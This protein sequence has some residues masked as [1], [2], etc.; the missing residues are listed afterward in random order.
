[1]D[2]AMF[3]SK[4]WESDSGGGRDSRDSSDDKLG[5]LPDLADKVSICCLVKNEETRQIS[6]QTNK[7]CKISIIQA[8]KI[9]FIYENGAARRALSTSSI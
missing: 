3:I 9:H 5:G 6:Q 7:Q 1:M 4:F 8:W 2:L